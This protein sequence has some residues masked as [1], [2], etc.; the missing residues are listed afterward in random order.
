MGLSWHGREQFSG[1]AFDGSEFAGLL[2][3]KHM[4]ES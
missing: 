3:E 4:Y 1:A 2:F